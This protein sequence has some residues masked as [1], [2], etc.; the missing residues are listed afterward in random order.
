MPDGRGLIGFDKNYFTTKTKPGTYA[1]GLITTCGLFLRIRCPRIVVS[2]DWPQLSIR[3]QL[4]AELGFRWQ[5]AFFARQ[6]LGSRAS[7]AAEH[8]SD[9][10]AF[11]AAHQCAQQCA[12]CRAAAHIHSGALVC[13][14]SAGSAAA[15]GTC[16]VDQVR[17]AVH[18]YGTQIKVSVFAV[19][20]WDGN[21]ASARSAR[22]QHV[23]G[24]VFY[25]LAH[26]GAV[27]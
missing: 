6:Y 5:I 19:I 10:C 4:I 13:A 23:A 25:V 7:S 21:Q 20:G 2:G 8:C 3:R 15:A 18:G 24:A 26:A 17:C 14:Q 1:P 27:T 11:A 12:Y 9:S 16:C 22:N